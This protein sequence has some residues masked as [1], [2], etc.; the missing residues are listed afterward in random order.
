MTVGYIA[1]GSNL[2]Q[3][4]QQLDSAI[5]ALRDHAQIT[6]RSHSPWYR[7]K[8][9]GP[10]EQPDYLNGVAVIETGLSARQLLDSLQEIEAAQ[11]RERGERWGARTLD[12]DIL[13]LGDECIESAELTL[14]H[15][16]LRER[17]FVL[18]PLYD[19]A[20]ELVLPCGTTLESLLA[21][22]PREGLQRTGE[23]IDPGR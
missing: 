16:R 11:G 19:V 5:T 2:G 9:V 4:R 17:N 13:L 3:P 18:Y 15:P 7:S 1:L 6:L 21:R 22:C 14:P 20:P 12:L 23:A 10:G 8:A